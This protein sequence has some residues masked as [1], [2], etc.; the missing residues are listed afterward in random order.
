MSLDILKQFNWLDIL[1]III[2]F[3]IGYSAMKIGIPLEFFKFLGTILAIYLAMHYYTSLVDWLMQ[4]AHVTKERIPLEFLEFLAFI[5]LAIVG[6]LIILS[7][8]VVFSHFIKMEA[9]PNLNK[10]M[11]LVLGIIRGFLLASLIIFILVISSTAYLKR[12]VVN[13][14][15]GRRIVNLAPNTYSWVWNKITSK[16]I[17]DEKFNETILE[18]QKDLNL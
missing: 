10:W 13:S 1:I 16:F 12:S 14:Y 3:R 17:T 8:R 9:T 15:F 7:L 5:F 4:R 11:G 6:Y 2:L 18:V